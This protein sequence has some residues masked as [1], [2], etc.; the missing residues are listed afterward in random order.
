MFSPPI[1]N[2]LKRENY[3]GLIGPELDTF[4]NTHDEVVLVVADAMKPMPEA[5]DLAIILPELVKAFEHRF[6]VVAAPFPANRELKLRYRFLKIPTLVFLRRGEYL[7]VISGLRDWA[8]Y[9]REIGT[10][11]ASEPS[12]P[13]PMPLPQGTGQPATA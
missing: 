2:L 13:P 11:L 9:L 7:G 1:A 12:E 10:I 8:D 3:P 4:L 5:V 6:A